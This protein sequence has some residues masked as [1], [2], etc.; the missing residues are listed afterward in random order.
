[1]SRPILYGND[2]SG[3]SYKAAL[4]LALLGMDAEYRHVDLGVSRSDRPTAFRE[5]S[6]FGEVPVLQHAGMSLCQSNVIL[7]YLAEQT[8]RFY[9]ATSAQRWRVREWLAWEANRVGFSVPNLRFQLKFVKGPS[10]E[11]LDYLHAR[12]VDDLN[13]LEAELSGRTFLVESSPT[14]ADLSCAG[15]LFWSD[16]AGLEIDHWPA[17][18]AW[19]ERIRGLENWRSPEDL[20]S[21]KGHE[22]WDRG[23][24]VC[25]DDA[26]GRRR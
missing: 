4:L 9:G 6:L 2:Q 8:G 20:L 26:S 24:Q 15:Y 14:I 13:R 11:L 10:M 19:L 5:A 16:E 23:Y 17:V 25:A 21:R 1:M 3:H 12:A 22:Q 18:R 7:T